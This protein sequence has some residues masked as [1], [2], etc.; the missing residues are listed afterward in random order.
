[1]KLEPTDPLVCLPNPNLEPTDPNL[2]PNQ[3]RPNTNANKNLNTTNQINKKFEREHQS[4]KTYKCK[5]GICGKIMNSSEE[6]KLHVYLDHK[7]RS[8]G[9]DY[10]NSSSSNRPVIES[11]IDYTSEVHVCYR[12]N[13]I[14]KNID[15]L[16]QHNEETCRRTRLTSHIS[17]I[18][19]I[20]VESGCSIADEEDPLNVKTK[21]PNP[22]PN[23]V[24]S[25]T[26]VNKNLNPLKRPKLVFPQKVQELVL[27]RVKENYEP[28]YHD[29]SMKNTPENKKAAWQ[30]LTD[31]ANKLL[32]KEKPG[33]YKVQDI[34]KYL[35][36]MLQ[37]V[38]IF[39]KVHMMLL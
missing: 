26:N 23:Q 12:C 11:T 21:Q 10:G 7:V 15:L 27:L 28:L 24:R 35:L 5:C 22:Q 18:P 37:K 8:T 38:V 39:F 25:N 34:G 6:L 14:F 29:I 4:T 1:M 16:N 3:V 33:C 31:Y 17:Q 19:N 2:E 36:V 13:R 20:S 30:N 32:E 9:I